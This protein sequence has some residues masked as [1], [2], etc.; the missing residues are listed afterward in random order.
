MGKTTLLK[1]IANRKFPI[2]PN[3]D[4]LYCEQEIEV[5]ETP[6]IQAVIN[7]DKKR[8]DLLNEEKELSAK[9]ETGDS[10]ITVRLKQVYE[11]L[12]AIGADTAEARARRILSG[13]QFT[14]KM[15]EKPTN[16]FSGGWRM[17]VSLARAL[18]MEPTLLLL[19]EPT[20][21]LVIAFFRKLNI[22]Y[23]TKL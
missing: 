2:P 16:Q 3:I 18:F 21:H 11:E 7:A 13:L 5:D 14:K 4:I 19:D 23:Y 8:L 6:A 15:Q 9:M 22:F 10:S 12:R 1:H 17:R 20:N